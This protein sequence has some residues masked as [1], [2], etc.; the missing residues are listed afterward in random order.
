MQI[1]TQ[2]ALHTVRKALLIALPANEVEPEPKV[3]KSLDLEEDSHAF[4]LATLARN[5]WPDWNTDRGA[6]TRL[7]FEAA[8]NNPAAAAAEVQGWA[9]I[10]ITGREA[11]DGENL[12][13]RIPNRVRG[14]LRMVG[15]FML[16]SFQEKRWGDADESPETRNQHLFGKALTGTYAHTVEAV[17]QD[18]GNSPGELGNAAMLFAEHL[19][20]LPASPKFLTNIA[21][22]RLAAALLET[23]QKLGDGADAQ[24]KT[25]DKV[26]YAQPA[27]NVS[28]KIMDIFAAAPENL[29]E[30]FRKQFH[31]LQELALHIGGACP[32]CGSP[33]MGLRA[34]PR[35]PGG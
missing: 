9:E 27:W 22:T 30:D 32:T 18:A 21:R 12:P 17:Q 1:A 6:I 11:P 3:V 34:A 24:I 35:L 28:V 20:K 25:A 2:V 31:R 23:A 16:D 29:Q 19:Q 14:A 26:F 4:I 5:F 8:R 33:H 7:L 15:A 13:S 10:M